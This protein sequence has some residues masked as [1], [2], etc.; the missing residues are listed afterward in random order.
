[1]TLGLLFTQG[2]NIDS[3]L[4]VYTIASVCQASCLQEMEFSLKAFIYLPD[5]N[6]VLPLCCADT[7]RT[8]SVHAHWRHVAKPLLSSSGYTWAEAT[9][10]SCEESSGQPWRQAWELASK[11]VLKFLGTSRPRP[12]S[13]QLHSANIWPQTKR[14]G[15]YTCPTSGIPP[16][17]S[18]CGHFSGIKLPLFWNGMS[19]L[20]YI[21]VMVPV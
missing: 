16:V 6:A 15:N 8:W 1:M 21:L 10:R 3:V 20:G 11:A 12:S 13:C 18:S 9:S 5:R 17:L 2:I 4:C 14:T 7:V 19:I